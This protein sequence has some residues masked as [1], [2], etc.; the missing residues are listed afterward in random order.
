LLKEGVV[1]IKRNQII[2]TL[3]PFISILIIFMFWSLLPIKFSNRSNSFSLILLIVFIGISVFRTLLIG[4]L[5]N[6]K[7]R[8]IGSI[9]SCSQSISYEISLSLI[10]FRVV[11]VVNSFNISGPLI[12]N[13][14]ILFLTFPILIV[15][16]ISIIAECN[17]APLDFAEGE[18]ELVRGFNVEYGRGSFALI[19]VAEYGIIIYFSLLTTLLFNIYSIWFIIPFMLLF[20]NMILFVR[21]AYPRLRYDKLIRVAWVK[22]LPIRILFFILIIIVC[23]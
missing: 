8:M 9:R 21:A 3:A 12:Y 11:S 19:F 17:R 5:S 16:V 4:W 14:S 2:F 13:I 22:M 7:F 1:I 20:L 15:W 10:I 23:N 18:S 6:S